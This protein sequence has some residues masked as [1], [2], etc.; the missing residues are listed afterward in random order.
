MWA[1]QRMLKISWTEKVT[2]KEVLV[3]ANEAK[4]IL[5]MIW[6]RRHRWLGHV[7]LLH[8]I[9]EGKMFDKATTQGRKK[10]ELLHDMM[11]VRNYGQLKDLISEDQDGDRTASENACQK[12][13]ENSRRLK[14]CMFL[15]FNCGCI[16]HCVVVVCQNLQ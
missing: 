1:W 8:D 14:K 10:I 5:K 3:R 12:P 2:N 16:S 15:I 13:A 9:T 4:S 7:D 11:E 6:C